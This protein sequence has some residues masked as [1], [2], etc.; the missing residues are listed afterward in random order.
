MMGLTDSPFRAIQVLIWAMHSI[1]ENKN[2]SDLP[3]AKTPNPFAWDRV[4][5][6]LPGTDTYD[7]TKPRVA[8]VEVNGGI[9]GGICIYCDKV[10]R[11]VPMADVC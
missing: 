6:N 11:T 9:A 2:D 8:K 10:R 4:D 7:P 5:L 3:G 1:M